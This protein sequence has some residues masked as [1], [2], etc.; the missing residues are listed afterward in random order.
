MSTEWDRMDRIA[1]EKSEVMQEFEK[2][3]LDEMKKMAQQSQK[4][5]QIS[6]LSKSL[7]QA[8]RSAQNLKKTLTNFSEDEEGDEV[9]HDTH[10]QCSCKLEAHGEESSKEISEKES[11]RE[12]LSAKASLLSELYMMKQGFLN[13]NDIVSVYSVERIIQEIE[14]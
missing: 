12:Y 11:E 4:T 5:K 7:Q 9:S 3:I 6:D 13:E 14:E 2:I 8:D 10:D 1:Y